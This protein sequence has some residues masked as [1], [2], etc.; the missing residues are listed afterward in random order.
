MLKKTIGFNQFPAAGEAV[1]TALPCTA[2]A[3]PW[4]KSHAEQDPCMS[5][6]PELWVYVHPAPPFCDTAP[7]H[8]P[9]C[10]QSWCISTSWLLFR[11][12]GN[13]PP[14][15][16]PLLPHLQPHGG[17]HEGALGMGTRGSHRVAVGF[18]CWMVVS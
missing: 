6:K 2:Q 7:Y 18:L 9:I 5:H 3:W 10:L 11:I 17:Q 13:K 15:T 8:S 4:C 14:C 12:R 16:R 1:C